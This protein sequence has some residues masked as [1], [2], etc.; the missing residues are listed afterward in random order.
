[1]TTELVQNFPA[2]YSPKVIEAVLGIL[3]PF[4][5]VNM[6]LDP[7]AGV[8]GIHELREHGY[9]TIGVEI[10][11]E[12]ARHGEIECIVGDSTQYRLDD[13]DIVWLGA[14]DG[15]ST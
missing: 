11:P 15:L 4:D 1:M 5:D 13:N 14:Q 8:G 7:C 6:I 12:F 2:K 10:E 9:G 3:A